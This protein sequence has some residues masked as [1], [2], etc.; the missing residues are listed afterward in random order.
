MAKVTQQICGR[1][2]TTNIIPVGW[3]IPF[4]PK[5]EWWMSPVK[6][7]GAWLPAVAEQMVPSGVLGMGMSAWTSVVE[8]LREGP[9]GL[10]TAVRCMGM[11]VCQAHAQY[12]WP[13]PH[14]LCLISLFQL[15]PSCLLFLSRGALCPSWTAHLWD[16]PLPHKLWR[17]PKPSCLNRLSC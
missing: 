13:P 15:S 10:R 17:G 8:R 3:T 14:F 11:G 9:G 5:A 6:G 1:A 2:R 12:P 7:Q 4:S 16:K